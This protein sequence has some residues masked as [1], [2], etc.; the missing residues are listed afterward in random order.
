MGSL[1]LGIGKRWTLA[2]VCLVGL[3]LSITASATQ[4]VA[5]PVATPRANAIATSG[6]LNGVACVSATW[7]MAVG[8]GVPVNSAPPDGKV[9]AEVWNGSTWS[10]HS[11]VAPSGSTSSVLSGVTCSSTTN[12]FAVGSYT[13]ATNTQGKVLIYRW[14]GSGWTSVSGVPM[15]SGAAYAILNGVTCP[16]ATRCVAVGY[17]AKTTSAALEPLAELWSGTTWKIDAQPAAPS[18]DI[19]NLKA[20][21]CLSTTFCMAVGDRTQ[22]TP[23]LT[24]SEYGN[25]TTWT[26]KNPANVT[27]AA[28]YLNGLRCTSTKSCVAVGNESTSVMAE[29]WNGSSWSIVK[30]QNPTGS[31]DNVLSS[32]SCYNT[33]CMAV[34]N[35]LKS[36]ELVTLT[37]HLSGTQWLVRPSPNVPGTGVESSLNAVSCASTTV[38]FAVGFSRNG[39]SYATLGEK[40]TGTTWAI[41]PS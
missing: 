23:D 27:G 39:A 12:C 8:I 4:A 32:V 2:G 37:E 28:N 16:T 25:G 41:T 29:S 14:K 13:T 38:C 15:P 36:S 3:P 24:L 7:C 20:V 10:I 11:P 5:S 30:S 40:M 6:E 21:S 33:L 35:G 34:G 31:I 17:W 22:G 18:T 26:A 19:R 1:S 9:L